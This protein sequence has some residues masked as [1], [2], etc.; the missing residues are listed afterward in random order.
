M[1]VTGES[2]SAA[3][4]TIIIEKGNEGSIQMD[5]CV[6]F[7][8]FLLTPLPNAL[9]HVT[10]SSFISTENVPPTDMWTTPIHK[11]DPSPPNKTVTKSS[12]TFAKPLSAAL[13]SGAD[14]AR[15]PLANSTAGN[16]SLTTVEAN[17]T[18]NYKEIQRE[19][20]SLSVEER[21]R[22]TAAPPASLSSP[23]RQTVT[24]NKKHVSLR[25]SRAA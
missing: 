17:T 25:T 19:F 14:P 13:S 20:D 18:Q 8:N 6:Y 10:R 12:N 3:N 24:V 2:E 1:A 9:I 16:N 23:R 22:F 4:E 5:Y 21:A 7:L 11:I 15:Q